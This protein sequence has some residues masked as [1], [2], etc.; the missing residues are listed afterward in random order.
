MDKEGLIIG[1]L[2]PFLG[3]SAGAACVYFNVSSI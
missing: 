1:L 3:T 2:L